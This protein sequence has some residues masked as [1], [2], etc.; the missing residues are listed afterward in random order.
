MEQCS[1]LYVVVENGDPYTQIYNCYAEAVL[2]VLTKHKTSL[3]NACNDL[4]MPEKEEKTYLYI[5]KGIHI[6]I[7]KLKCERLLKQDRNE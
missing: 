1:H 2:A 5:E 7:Y 6:E 4:I 3:D